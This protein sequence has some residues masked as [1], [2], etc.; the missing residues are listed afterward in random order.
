MIKNACPF[1]PGASKP[2]SMPRP[3]KQRKSVLSGGTAKKLILVLSLL[4]LALLYA[5]AYPSPYWT[6]KSVWFQDW[7]IAKIGFYSYLITMIA[8]YFRLNRRKTG[9]L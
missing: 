4:A 3:A 7:Y 5:H 1:A 9:N 8:Y 6:G 2:S